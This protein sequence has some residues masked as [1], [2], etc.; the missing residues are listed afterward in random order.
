M[1]MD[2]I[3]DLFT[4]IRNALKARLDAIELPFS[5]IKLEIVKILKNEGFIKFFELKTIDENKK[6]IKV[7]LKYDKNGKAVI[8]YIKRKSKLNR[9]IYL[10]KKDIPK[11]LNGFGIAIMSTPKGILTGRAARLQGLGGEYIG[12]IY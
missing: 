2:P 3:A 5:V 11:V 6:R 8:S 1:I 7:G 12:E 9:R 10:K 4:Q